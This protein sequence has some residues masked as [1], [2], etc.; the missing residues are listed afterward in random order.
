VRSLQ[1]ET[2]TGRAALSDAQGRLRQLPTEDGLRA[3]E[4]RLARRQAAADQAAA[5]LSSLADAPAT[6]ERC[7]QE[8]AT[9][10]DPRREYQSHED[11]ARG[12]DELVRQREDTLAREKERATAAGDLRSGLAAY[13][14]LD[15]IIRL[16]RAERDAHL[17]AHQ[18]YMTHLNV[19]GQR[20]GRQSLVAELDAD[21]QRL[22]E[23]AT[24]A[25]RDHVEA[26]A[27][28]DT[29]GHTS[30]RQE[31][32]EMR[33]ELARADTRLSATRERQADVNAGIAHLE[34][35][36]REMASHQAEL[37]KLAAVQG[38]LRSTRELLRQAGPYVTRHLVHQISC[39][40]SAIHA[41]I[42]DDHTGR[43]QWSEDYDLSLQVKGHERNFRQFSGGEQMSAAL[44]LRLA[45]LRETSAI[46][47]AFFDEPTAH[48]DP[49]R[50][51][52]LAEKIMQVK[53]FSQVFVISHDDTFER[54]AQHYV[55]I[56]KD[57][58]G[59]H[60]EDD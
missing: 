33:D 45:L 25:E 8:L 44:A 17:A 20:A 56:I 19:A 31:V 28:Y 34:D 11:R 27:G 24:D 55:R 58:N 40:A 12:H 35:L 30:L 47:V 23:A 32:A 10:G 2:A 16:A 54:T 50:R 53:G 39:E 59:S 21:R 36:S 42:M 48:L 5:E 52:G 29:A 38:I 9:L 60:P 46:D 37:D 18:T 43:L 3:A 6:A 14:G 15:E 41:D 4:E 49:E 7:R 22:T 51:E 26:A 13:A 57:V 1:K